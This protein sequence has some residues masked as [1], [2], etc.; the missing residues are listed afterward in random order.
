MLVYAC[1][2]NVY[3]Q[4]VP[5]TPDHKVTAFMADTPVLLD[6]RYNILFA[7]H[8]YTIVET[9]TSMQMFEVWG[10]LAAP[11]MIS[12]SLPDPISVCPNMLSDLKKFS[13]GDTPFVLTAGGY[14]G[15]I[16]SV[17]PHN[18]EIQ[19]IDFKMISWNNKENSE[20]CPDSQNL[21]GCMF[22]DF[23]ASH[24]H[25][26]V[27]NNAGALFVYDF[28]IS[29]AKTELIDFSIS[30]A[31][32]VLVEFSYRL[33]NL[34]LVKIDAGKYHFVA[35]SENGSVYSWSPFA[36]YSECGHGN[37]DS[38]LRPTLIDA[39]SGIKI[40]DIACGLFH[41]AFVS[42]DG[43]LYTCGYNKYHQLGRS[44]ITLEPVPGNNITHDYSVPE[45]V[46][47]YTI[48]HNIVYPNVLS[49]YCGMHHT[50]ANTDKY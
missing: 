2:L 17:T 37:L 11:C 12:P 42:S 16:T 21:G 23:A 10:L 9:D 49:V 5:S 33:D 13:G 19:P 1:G 25:L 29:E 15:L 38:M 3:N 39:L 45:P 44:N 32:T 27:I 7:S 43:D 46:E 41:S 40:N 28:S 14:I 26:A 6:S 34:K 18:L 20:L 35:L 50:L 4:T 8:S 36:M 48:N 22:I 31:K 30:E 47:L 24:S